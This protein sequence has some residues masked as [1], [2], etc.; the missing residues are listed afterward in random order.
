MNP[1]LLTKDEESPFLRL[2]L[3]QAAASGARDLFLAAAESFGRGVEEVVEFDP[4]YKLHDDECFEIHDFPI[5]D[6]LI[7]FCRQ[8]LSAERVDSSDF[9]DLPINGIVGYDFS[10]GQRK[11]YFQ[12]FDSRRVLIPGRRFAVLPMADASTFKQLTEPVLLL[13]ANITAVWDNGNL[14]FKSFHLAKQLFDLSAYFTEATDEQIAQFVTHTRLQCV[15]SARFVG[16]CNTWSRTKIA[17]ILRGG[18]LDHATGDMIR[19]AAASVE[20][21]VQMVED[22][23]VLPEEKSELRSLLQFLDEDIY[24]GPISR[25]RLLSSGKRQ[26][27]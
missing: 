23:I 22:R 13:D 1:I 6:E 24:R 10:A 15:D 14:R 27:E 26:L 18:I 17:L 21:E 25:R 5:S 2:D 7:G 8:P 12:N 20:Y 3:D 19:D 11:L 16:A 4:G 9:A